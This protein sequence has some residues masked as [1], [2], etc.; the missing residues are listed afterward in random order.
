VVQPPA[1]PSALGALNRA[2][3]RRGVPWRYG[4]PVGLLQISDSGPLIRR[5]QVRRRYRL[6]YVGGAPR[7]VVATVVGE[8]W[9]VRSGSV[10]LLG[11]RLDPDWT[12]LPLS[13]A[14]VPLVDA[15]VNRLARGEEATI[16]ASPGAPVMLPDIATEVRLDDRTWSVEGGAPFRPPAIGTYF[17]LA[18]AD[19]VGALAVNVD[20][21]ESDLTPATDAAIRDLWPGVRIVSPTGARAA[22]FAAGARGDLRGPLLWAALLF[23][24]VEIALASGRRQ[25]AA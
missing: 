11:S 21:R 10:V 13:A 9:I 8:P 7:G 23:G 16:P 12:G 17:V 20:P 3:E 14:F 1:D 18:G 24:L 5:E 22:A 19:T 15:L 6:E 2:L 25:R 4:D